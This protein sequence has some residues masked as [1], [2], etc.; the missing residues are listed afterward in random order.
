MLEASVPRDGLQFYLEV[1]QG[2]LLQL[3][4][5][6]AALTPLLKTFAGQA[7]ISAQD[8]AG[9][10]VSHMS[11]LA[12]SRLAVVNYGGS[13]TAAMIEAADAAGAEAIK[14]GLAKLVGPSRASAEAG[15]EV[16]M[17]DRVVVAGKKNTVSRLV[18]SADSFS[19]S[20]DRTFMNARARFAG[21][22][23]F[24]YA[25][26]SSMPL[27][28]SRPAAD[29]NIDYMAGFLTGLASRPYAIVMGGSLRGDSVH[30]RALALFG[31][32]DAGG[33]M[34]GIFSNAASPGGKAVAASFAP[35]DADL[36]LDLMLDWDKLYDSIQSM[37]SMAASAMNNQAQQSGG[38]MPGLDLLGAIES[39]LG[40]SIKNDL[41]PT[42]GNEL[43]ISFSDFARAMKPALQTANYDDG[44]PAART[45]SRL[46]R[47]LVIAEL[48]DPAKFEKLFSRILNSPSQAPA[49]F[50][51]ETYRGAVIK[52]R[53]AVA[54][55]I[56]RNFFFF[57]PTAAEI[58]RALDA[59][60]TG[61]GLS[62]SAQFRAAVGSSE[63]AM[64]Q[65]YFS[66]SL[67]NTMLA[68][69]AGEAARANE[70][71]KDFAGLAAKARSAV[72]LSVWPDEEGLMM[73]IHMPSSLAF[74]G[75]AAMATTKPAPYGITSSGQRRSAGKRTPMLTTDDVRITRKP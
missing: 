8:F 31:S 30:L 15:I 12:G 36:F 46:P 42:L 48:R 37:F 50:S 34:A 17:R 68:S 27:V 40:F 52:S 44:Q 10:A 2:G 1:R 32:K 3:A 72:G 16:S 45:Q 66:P 5:A 58:R 35:Q 39:K 54:F 67:A 9:F 41:L 13:D 19:L 49:E 43:A 25:E 57:A 60:A 11:V 75:V 63:R 55:A 21:E 47:I 38:A 24:A 56:S 70:S 7:R 28:P 59:R 51:Q 61:N 73:E 6:S 18:G 69:M 4:Q 71:M 62:S 26:L 20:E 65:G 23:F 29:Q 64:L 33:L 53:G 14:E 22:P 74:M